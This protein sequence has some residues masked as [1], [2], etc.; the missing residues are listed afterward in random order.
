M[1]PAP[2]IERPERVPV[3][4]DVELDFEPPVSL[5]PGVEVET[6]DAL[7]EGEDEIL[8]GFLDAEDRLRD[9]GEYRVPP[10]E[11]FGRPPARTRTKY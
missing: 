6:D 7:L 9:L 5:L 4:P 3:G 2:D 1:P 8:E 10:P 11:E